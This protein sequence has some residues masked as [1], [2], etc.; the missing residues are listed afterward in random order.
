MF[1][2]CCFLRKSN[3]YKQKKKALSICLQPMSF[4]HFSLE[5]CQTFMSVQL[6]VSPA[7]RCWMST[8]KTGIRIST[9]ST[10]K[11]ASHFILHPA[12]AAITL[13]LKEAS[14]NSL[15]II[16]RSR[17]FCFTLQ[18]VT[19]SNSGISWKHHKT[20]YYCMEISN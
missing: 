10:T 4:H 20:Q 3:T 8:A 6:T 16:K 5:G 2:C 15:R 17:I 12:D 18:R 19:D 7:S 1:C 9:R 11:T 13:E 14:Q